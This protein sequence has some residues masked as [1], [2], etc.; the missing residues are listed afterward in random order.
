MLELIDPTAGH[1]GCRQLTG[2]TALTVRHFPGDRSAREA[3]HA[4]ALSWSEIPGTLTGQ[5]PYLAWRSPQETLALGLQSAPLQALL[6]TLAPGRSDSA[7]AV[8]LSESLAVFELHGPLLD[9]WLS[10]LVDAVAIPSQAGHV[11][12]CRLAD[13]AAL[14]LRL[15]TERV[16]L[17]ADRPVTPYL[18]NWLSYSHLGA[19][20]AER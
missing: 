1:P 17:V 12:R 8:D 16:W 4:L 13:I 15:D 10:H 2:V 20:G 14:L 19:F 5:D 6:H 9:V 3:T 18:G 11:S 7:I